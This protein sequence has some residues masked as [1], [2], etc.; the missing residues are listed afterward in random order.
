M[1]II[2]EKITLEEALKIAN[3]YACKIREEVDSN[4]KVYLFGSVARGEN[5][6]ESDI[7]IAVISKIFDK[8][9]V[10]DYAIVNRVGFSINSNIDARAI[11]YDDWIYTDPLTEKIQREGIMIQ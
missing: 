1:D 8:D 10:K 4:A 6:K 9:V 2:R 7:D 3:T 11:M 5:T